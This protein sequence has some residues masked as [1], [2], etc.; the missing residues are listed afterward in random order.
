MS[1]RELKVQP[2]VRRLT[3]RNYKV[4]PQLTLS[5]N[6]LKDAGFNPNSKVDLKVKEGIIIITPT[7]K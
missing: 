6:W 7:L 5:G 1:N 2:L 3:N 4:V